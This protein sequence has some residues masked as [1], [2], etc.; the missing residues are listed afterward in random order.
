M[1]FDHRPASL[2]GERCLQSLRQFAMKL[3]LGA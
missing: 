3:Q 1:M 2:P